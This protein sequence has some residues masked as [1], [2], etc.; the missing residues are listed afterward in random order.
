MDKKQLHI[1][2]GIILNADCSEIYIT[3]RAAKAHK[4]GY[5]EFA[6]G[7]VEQGETAEQAVI[8]ELEEE[9]GIVAT[10]LEAFISLAH[11]YPD[12][13]LRF[14]FYL[15][16]AFDGEPFGKEGQPG[17]WAKIAQLDDYPFPEANDA[18]LEKIR[19][20]FGEV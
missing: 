1:A 2:A 5:W 3:Q 13:A 20:A 12:K 14:D 17:R 8:R 16:K 18:V 11:D 4:G 6:G 19:K 10:R 15:V 9:V 7:K